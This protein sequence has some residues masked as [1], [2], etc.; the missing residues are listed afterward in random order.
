MS[1]PSAPARY[2]VLMGSGET[3][4]TMVRTH[5][6]VLAAVAPLPG[7]AVLLD[8]PFGFQE[9]A[10]DITE[11][12][13]VYFAQSVGTPI[14]VATYRRDTRS[15]LERER[16][17]SSVRQARYVFA[18]PGSPT[19]AL[20][21]WQD[22]GLA[23]LLA[24]KLRH[25]GAVVFASAAALTLGAVS[26]PVYEIYK[27]GLPPHW[28]PG[29]DVLATVGLPVAVIPHYNN[30]EGGNHD[31]RYC[32]LGERRLRRMEEELPTGVFVLG[33]DEHT[34]LVV[35]LVAGRARVVGIGRVVVRVAG[36]SEEL[37]TGSEL[38]LAQLAEIAD[39]L[40]RAPGRPG[41][42]A[43]SSGTEPRA[44]AG[45]GIAGDPTGPA[46]PGGDNL[47]GDAIRRAETAFD[48]ALA[49]RDVPAALESLLG[50][51]ET[52]EAWSA[53]TLQSSD[54][55]AGRRALR[56]MILRLGS[57][58]EVGAR[59]TE[60]IVGPFVEIVLD[61]RSIAR[62]ERRWAAADQLR[63]ALVAAGVQIHDTPGG[64]RWE[65]TP[66]DGR[67]ESG[68]VPGPPVTPRE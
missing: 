60:A 3:A 62:S 9:N 41:D 61:A 38:P 55:E 58:A 29:L 63:D 42:T 64:T 36:R 8:T 65:L 10:D 13:Q 33:V 40:R 68:P 56:A 26:V 22:V 50:L 32:Y 34:G 45:A 12:A 21:R 46:G 25:G 44:T 11:R 37:P 16:F 53:D 47:L 59:P 30:A 15:T 18:G 54:R 17:L 35:D 48:A 19:Y 66:D 67:A 39:A 2:L 14:E 31:T 24:D 57:L 1:P 49:A 28:E 43:T 5:R 52:L 51:E 6:E 23:P 7:P 4:P 27:V 20:A